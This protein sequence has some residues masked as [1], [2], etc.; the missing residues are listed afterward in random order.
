[1]TD[2]LEYICALSPTQAGMLLHTLRSP[3]STVW[4]V[5]YVVTFAGDLD[6]DA[7]ERAWQAT[8]QRHAI[9]RTAFYWQGL[10]KPLQVAYRTVSVHLH[11]RDG[12]GGGS[13]TLDE[14][15]RADR[16]KMFDLSRPPAMRISLIRMPAGQH[17]LIWTFH[18]IILDG[19]SLGLVLRDAMAAYQAIRAGRE[20]GFAPSPP[21]RDFIAWLQRQDLTSAENYWRR[22]LRGF[23]AATPLNVAPADASESSAREE[24]GKA[25]LRLT[26]EVTGR[27]GALAKA[28]RVPLSAVVVAAWALLLAQRSQQDDVVFGVTMSG[29]PAALPLVEERVGLF[30]NTLPIRLRI[31]SQVPLPTWLETVQAQFAELQEY[32][33]SPLERVQA[34]SDLPQGAAMFDSH[35]VFENY[36]FN[37]AGMQLAA[38]I[39]MTH[40]ESIEQSNYPLTVIVVPGSELHVRILYARKRFAADAIQHLLIGYGAVLE[41]IAAAPQ[42]PVTQLALISEQGA[43]RTVAACNDA[44]GRRLGERVAE[45]VRP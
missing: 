33:H 13:S 19:W 7:L 41:G 32:S 25:E 27:L 1:M 23:R 24:V 45:E 40:A 6:G 15:A 28:D 5:Q 8:V 44:G 29:R 12:R 38:G 42:G 2:N 34:W 39:E 18:H 11:R 31:P 9:L 3:D 37:P 21:Y 14:F 4:R 17:A 26:A 43:D 30:I 20:A 16:E 35:L 36:P 10:E 22:V